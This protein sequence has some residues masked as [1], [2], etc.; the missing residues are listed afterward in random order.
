MPVLV[1]HEQTRKQIA[2]LAIG[3]IASEGIE[4]LT[5]RRMAEVAG[6]SRGIVSTY[7]RDMRD[8]TLAA[9]GLMVERQVALLEEVESAG[10][11]LRAC[12]EALLPIDEERLQYW[13]V[14]I[15]FYGM[16]LADPEL[17]AFQR[18][19]I[20]GAVSRFERILV[21]ERGLS[22]SSAAVRES[23]QRI[24]SATIGEAVHRVFHPQ[25]PLTARER[26]RMVNRVLAGIEPTR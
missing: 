20:D 4:G 15:A 14:V 3:I 18:E 23:A 2:Q 21:R 5:T 25:D 13:R 26:T 7:F 1:D 19:R 22:R 24:V 16:A 6:T 12:V 9:F 10:G 8:L 17:A 11:G